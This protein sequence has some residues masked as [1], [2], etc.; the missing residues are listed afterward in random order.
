[1]TKL[2]GRKGGRIA[3]CTC[4]HCKTTFTSTYVRK[5]F[6]GIMQCDENKTI[7]V[8]T[9]DQVPMIDRNKYMRE[10]EAAQNKSKKSRVEFETSGSHR[11]F[12]GSIAPC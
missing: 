3:K 11:M 5:S 6:C 7:G 10:E 8:K 12:G 2:E 1:V 9:F 4:F